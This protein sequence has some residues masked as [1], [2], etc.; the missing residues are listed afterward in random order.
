M[1]HTCSVIADR[2]PSGPLIAVF[3]SVFTYEYRCIILSSR[4]FLHEMSKSVPLCRKIWKTPFWGSRNK[5]CAQVLFTLAPM[6]SLL[7]LLTVAI[8]SIQPRLWFWTISFLG[9]RIPG[10]FFWSVCTVGLDYA[11][12]LC[13]WVMRLCYAISRAISIIFVKEFWRSSAVVFS[14][15]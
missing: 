8:I 7:I 4:F 6:R 15:G 2:Q 11:T 13:G 5:H 10:W 14:S 9:F 3:H 12:G 1:A